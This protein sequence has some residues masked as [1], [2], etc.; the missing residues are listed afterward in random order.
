VVGLLVLVTAS[1]AEA[2]PAVLKDKARLRAGASAATELL[3]ELPPGARV[4]ILAD[5]GGWRQVQTADGQ[6]GYVWAEHLVGETDTKPAVPRAEAGGP[7]LDEVREL[8]ADVR[9]LRERPEPATAA[10]LERVR[11]DVQRLLTTQEGLVRRLEQH[12]VTDPAPE[13]NVGATPVLLFAAAVAGWVVSRVTLRR[14]DHRQRDR[15]RF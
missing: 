12:P 6:T 15:L 14:R 1:L 13:A 9:A 3:G 2:R 10:D 8:R 7:L 11:E 5:E 4:E